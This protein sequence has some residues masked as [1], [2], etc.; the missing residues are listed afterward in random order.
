MRNELI[1]FCVATAMTTLVSAFQATVP[2]SLPRSICLFP[3]VKSYL[4]ASE[5]EDSDSDLETFLTSTFPEY[6]NLLTKSPEWKNVK[7]S[8][9]ASTFFAPNSKAFMDLGDQKKMQMKDERNLELIEKLA[10][11][12]VIAE[13]AVGEE[14][15]RTEDWTKPKPTDGSPRPLTVGAILTIGG[16]VPVGRSKS[17]GFLGLFAKE[18]GGIVVG[19]NAKILKSYVVGKNVVH[20]VDKFISPD[21]IWRFA[22][23]LRIP[24]I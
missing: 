21:I 4:K 13:E 20:E 2:T 8:T 1:G 9:Q 14:R 5:G 16:E 24:G 6:H 3:N 23:Q 15:L 22:D 10:A 17:G 18:D 11:Y 12:H 19:A 7:G